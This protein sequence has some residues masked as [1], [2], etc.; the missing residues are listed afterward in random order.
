MMCG[1]GDRTTCFFMDD[2]QPYGDV[3]IQGPWSGERYSIFLSDTYVHREMTKLCSIT[4]KFFLYDFSSTKKWQS[5]KMK[6]IYE[7]CT[8][9]YLQLQIHN[10]T[11]PFGLDCVHTFS[12]PTVSSVLYTYL[13]GKLFSICSVTFPICC[14]VARSFWNHK[15]IFNVVFYRLQRST[16]RLWSFSF[17]QWQVQRWRICGI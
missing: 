4:F 17:S 5:D 8:E 15:Q 13:A 6:L 10:K 7:H 11:S 16:L 2:A 3:P 1:R 12:V 9:N 14:I